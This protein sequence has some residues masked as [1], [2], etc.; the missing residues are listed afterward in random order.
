M[1]DLHQRH[2]EACSADA[3]LVSEAEATEL[4]ERIPDWNKQLHEGVEK[5]SR[6]FNFPTFRDAFDFSSRIATLAEAED[7]HP[8]ILTEWG[9][10]TVFWWTHKIGGLHVNDF[11]M[12]ARTDVIYEPDAPKQS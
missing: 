8:A 7:H 12:A 1:D 3:P 4:Q 9:K 11:I 10:V 2:C 5:L 6:E